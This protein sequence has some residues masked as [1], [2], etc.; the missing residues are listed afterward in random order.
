MN[1]PKTCSRFYFLAGLL[2]LLCAC[3]P[4]HQPRALSGWLDL[5]GYDFNRSGPARLDGAWDLYW[6]QLVGPGELGLNTREPDG[7]F[8]LPGVW[9]QLK[10]RDGR[11]IASGEGYATLRLRVLLPPGLER[12]ALKLPIASTAYRLWVNGQML[13]ENGT[14]SKNSDSGKPQN[15]PALVT[16]TIPRAHNE[17]RTVDLVLQISNYHMPR[18]GMR[19]G[20]FLGTEEQILALDRRQLGLEF[21]L[22]GC[23]IV[24]GFY[25]LT[26]FF[27][28]REELSLL[29]FACCS[30][31]IALRTMI[32]GERF[33]S[34][35]APNVIP[36]EVDTA[37]DF[38]TAAIT[39][40][41]FI[42]YV[43]ALFP[44]LASARLAKLVIVVAL[45]YVGLVIFLPA[46]LY[47]DQIQWLLFLFGVLGLYLLVRMTIA[48]YKKESGT[49]LFLFGFVL[50]L[51][52]F[53]NDSLY[54][55]GII[56]SIRLTPFG[57][58]GFIFTQSVLISVKFSNAFRR[59]ESMS[60]SMRRFVPQDFLNLLG[61]PQ[62]EDVRLGDQVERE[63]T[64]LFSDIRD[65]TSLSETMSP[66]ENFEFLNALLRR[67]G[68]LIREHG[69][70]IDK[71]IG[72][73]IMA[74]FAGGP[75][76]ALR[77]AIRMTQELAA[78]NKRR[79]AQG[80]PEIKMGVGIHTGRLML[81]TVGEAERL[82]GTVISDA[83]N[84]TSRI[85]GQNKVYGSQI[86]ISEATFARLKASYG[87]RTLGF[88][89]LKGKAKPVEIFEAFDGD[90][91]D[92][93]R[94]KE[95][96]RNT[97][98]Q[99]VRAISSG[100]ISQA[101]TLFKSVLEYNPEDKAAA[102]LMERSTSIS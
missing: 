21:L 54:S 63:M 80:F 83:V 47:A 75:D 72:D 45:I 67:L 1:H 96:T 74:L 95:E 20:I 97:F 30:L 13:S 84:L 10:L 53:V 22:F 73:G 100:D 99:G 59:I 61:R 36:W 16:F 49:W 39:P 66:L 25:H 14:V 46:R 52:A 23:L 76:E 42:M 93:R 65:F 18:G 64:I 92:L 33:L 77:A 86:L 26:L 19:L 82:E 12:L 7:A 79:L 9:N 40:A 31:L 89:S 38:I 41:F 24:I 34:V 68:P 44:M 28:R 27:L 91:S 69:G 60:N 6:A 58:L 88:A 87:L 11:V 29:F 102:F 71:Y 55:V 70:F 4:G 37:L 43:R 94:A 78:Y 48:A 101:R 57:L 51:L 32:T 8:N 15:R 90:E 81:G 3:R 35:L 50:L 85:E 2:L 17:A 56:D 98:E 62:I 5:S